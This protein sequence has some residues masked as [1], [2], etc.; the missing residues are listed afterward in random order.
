[1]T[2]DLPSVTLA[3]GALGTAATGL[4]D[5]TKVFGPIGTSR[6]GFGFIKKTMERLLPSDA[7]TP[8]SGLVRADIMDTLLANWLNGMDSGAQIAAATSFVK[9]HLNPQSSAGLAEATGVDRTLLLNVAQKLK[10]AGTLESALTA[11]ETDTFGRF[12]LSVATLVD[13][14]YQ[15]ADQLYRNVCKSLACVV[16]VGLAF[17]ANCQM[18]PSLKWWQVL[19]IGLIA[20]PLAPM[21]KD[22]AN[23]IQ[24]A[25]DSLSK[26]KG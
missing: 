3:V 10:Q 20:T 5:T 24:T 23:A 12:D 18:R 21:V 8:D 9:L 4:V 17:L 1:M 6:V 15:R 25:S 16:A 2:L 19:L 11:D 14:S 26:I 7:Q 13:K 22:I